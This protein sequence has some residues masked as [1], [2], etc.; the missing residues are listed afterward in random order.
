MEHASIR[1]TPDD[2][3]TWCG[4]P[5]FIRP[6]GG[7]KC[8]TT[9]GAGPAVCMQGLCLVSERNRPS[10][11]APHSGNIVLNLGG[12]SENAVIA[13]L[14]K[15]D[16]N[17][18]DTAPYTFPPSVFLTG[19]NSNSFASGLLKAGDLPVPSLS[20]NPGWGRPLPEAW[21]K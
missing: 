10:D 21:F 11:A 4:Q 14:L 19:A 17:Y 1:I 13:T 16:A 6:E 18:S 2:Q 3:E 9:L 7:G 5:G 20:S 15:L 12:R 8:F